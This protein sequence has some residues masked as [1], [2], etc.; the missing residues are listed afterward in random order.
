MIVHRM[1]ELPSVS[2]STRCPVC[3]IKL[4]FSLAMH[5]VAA[6]SANAIEN[7]EK[8]PDAVFGHVQASAYHHP[9]PNPPSESR[10][11]NQV[12]KVKSEFV[13]RRENRRR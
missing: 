8:T 7:A 1:N 11:P 5:M 3:N 9:R 10:R 6:H 13:G 4:P 12:H 2:D